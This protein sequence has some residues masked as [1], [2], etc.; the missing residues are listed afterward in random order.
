MELPPETAADAARVAM[1]PPIPVSDSSPV[2]PRA[3]AGDLQPATLVASDDQPP[4]PAKSVNVDMPRSAFIRRVAADDRDHDSDD[5]RARYRQ[6]YRC[7]RDHNVE[8]A[9]DCPPSSGDPAQQGCLD[10]ASAQD[11]QSGDGNF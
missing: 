7:A 5:G 10:Y 6:G 11:R 8:V 4:A 2:D 9:Q 1:P 3:S